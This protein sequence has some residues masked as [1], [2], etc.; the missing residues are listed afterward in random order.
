[1]FAVVRGIF[2]NAFCKN[3]AALS[4]FFYVT[5]SL[6]YVSFKN[7][8]NQKEEKPPLI[9]TFPQRLASVSLYQS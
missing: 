2:Q 3:R 5:K 9:S 1:M 8:E 6:F 7:P 4:H